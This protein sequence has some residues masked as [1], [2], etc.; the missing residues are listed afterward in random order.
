MSHSKSIKDISLV[1]KVVIPVIIF[2]I[3]FALWVGRIIFIEKY[4]SE[5][6]G[7]INTAKA[8]FSALIPIGEI[9]V[10]GANILKL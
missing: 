6:A 2:S 7:I 5:K 1:F 4:D 3:I 10:S 9:S 8:A